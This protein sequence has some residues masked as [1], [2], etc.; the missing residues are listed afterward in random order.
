MTKAVAA[1]F[2]RNLIAAVPYKLHTTLTDNGIRFIHHV[3][4]T[5]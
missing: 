4:H 1:Y 5:T 2:L 3:R